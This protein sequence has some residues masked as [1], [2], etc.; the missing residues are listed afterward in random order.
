M[1]SHVE[2]SRRHWVCAMLAGASST[3]LSCG[4]RAQEVGDE[5]TLGT[6]SFA[7]LTFSH[8][9]HRLLTASGALPRVA[10]I[11]DLASGKEVRRLEGHLAPLRSATFSP[12]E[13]QVVTGAGTGTF[14]SHIPPDYTARIW[15]A[16]TGKEL[17]QLT[18]HKGF[19]YS[20]TFNPD[21]SR[22]LTTGDDSIAILWDAKTGKPLFQFAN[23]EFQRPAR[24]SPNGKLILGVRGGDGRYYAQLWDADSGRELRRCEGHKEE[25]TD[26]RFDSKGAR[27]VTASQDASARLWDVVTAKELRVLARHTGW[28]R[29][30]A[31]S[32]DNRQVVTASEDKTAKLWDAETGAEVRS[33]PHFGPVFKAELNRNGTRLMTISDLPV[34]NDRIENDRSPV[35]MLWE[36]ST[37]RKVAQMAI[38]NSYGRDHA[39]FSLDGKSFFITLYSTAVLCSAETGATIREYK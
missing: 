18:G 7:S 34:G 9:G 21:A 8:D 20:A 27:V 37:G 28:L 11:W 35:A 19:V 15:D 6:G 14:L 24:F 22:I 25:L 39:L 31:F 16:T 13:K 5:K 12:D 3:W 17:K 32:A 36:V 23:I 38:N 2:I 33:F 26:A 1:P 29:S 4:S 10:Q 30:A